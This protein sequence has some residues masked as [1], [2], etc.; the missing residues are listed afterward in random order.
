[1]AAPISVIVPTLNEAARIGPLLASLVPGL[2]TGLIAELILADGG[3][4][5]ATRA[6]GERAGARIVTASPGRGRQ[7][8]AG[9]A[10][11]RGAWFLVLH[12]DTRL[13]DGWTE[14]A[15]GHL[16]RHPGDAGYFRLAFDAP[17]FFP[18]L[19][20]GW[21]NLR[22]RLFGLPWGDQGLL[23]PRGLYARTGGYRPIPLMEDV[24]MA[25]A[26]R[27]RLRLLPCTL[28][29]S[30]ERYRAEGWLRRGWRN[31][32]LVLAFLLGRDAATIARAYAPPGN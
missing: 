30:A 9:C 26:L 24:A 4:E 29:T 2:E 31:Q 18:S 16:A 17:G 27:G 20:A 1:M 6:I 5:D 19:T 11:A 15:A 25:R 23:L 13:P 7:L 28:T 14:A 32:R 22:S 8:A 12:A 10:A 21:A 3:S